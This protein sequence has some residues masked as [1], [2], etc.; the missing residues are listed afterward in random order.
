MKSAISWPR[1]AEAATH[2]IL[3]GRVIDRRMSAG[4]SPQEA[5]TNRGA[6]KFEC[7]TAHERSCGLKSALLRQTADRSQ[8]R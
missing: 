3:R 4:L 1:W 2:S 5:A 6:G 7:Q 8:P